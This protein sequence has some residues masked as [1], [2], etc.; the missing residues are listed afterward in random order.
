MGIIYEEKSRQFHLYNDK[1]SYIMT[2]LP[3]GQLGQLY[4]GKR[5]RHRESFGHLLEFAHR[6]M[7]PCVYEDD[8]TFSLEHIRQE[9]PAFG[10][11]DMR[12]PAYGI[13]RENGSRVSCFV[14]KS[15]TIQGGKPELPGLP[16]VYVEQDEEA[17]TL[18]LYLE[19]P[20]AGM[21]LVLLYTIYEN[22]P[23]LTR[24]ARFICRGPEPVCLERAMSL[25]LDLPD[26]RYQM[27]DLTG[28]WCRER[29]VDCHGL[30]RGVQSIHSMRGHSSHQFNPFICLKR[31]DAG[32]DSGEVIGISLVYSGNFLAQAEVD[33]MDTVRVTMGIHPEGFDWPLC[34][35][36]EF[37][38]PEA[39]MVYSGDG[40][41]GMS[42]AFH[43]L[44][45][46]RLARGYWRDRE[47]P[48]LINNWEATYMDF[49]EEKILSIADNAPPSKRQL[50]SIRRVDG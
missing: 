5:L 41:N 4:Y 24:S 23:V 43:Q 3:N 31:P 20:V 8:T 15:H 11:G 28:A 33:T 10:T 6:D 12:Y 49:D 19:D 38:T 22:M 14:Y 27:V 37:Q 7:A 26:P 13:R 39:V 29:Y 36:E 25:S 1:I 34:P 35:G 42:Q 47:R 50:C 16:A 46:T 40:L 30:H 48:I 45:R 21:E 32:E 2:C 9:Y 17:Q 18:E 44:Y